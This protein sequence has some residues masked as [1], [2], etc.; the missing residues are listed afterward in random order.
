MGRKKN[1][2]RNSSSSKVVG[3]DQGAPSTQKVSNPAQKLPSYKVVDGLQAAYRPDAF[4]DVLNTINGSNNNNKDPLRQHHAFSKNLSRDQLELAP[5]KEQAVNPTKLSYSAKPSRDQPAPNKPSSCKMVGDR[6]AAGITG[7]TLANLCADTQNTTTNKAPNR[8][9]FPYVS[10]AKLGRDHAFPSVTGTKLGHDQG[11]LNNKERIF[12]IVEVPSAEMVEALHAALK[13]PNCIYWP[14]KGSSIVILNSKMVQF[15][16]MEE[17]PRNEVYEVRRIF[18]LIA[19]KG[20]VKWIGGQKGWELDSDVHSWIMYCD[21]INKLQEVYNSFAPDSIKFVDAGGASKSKLMFWTKQVSI[22][23]AINE[24]RNVLEAI[25]AYDERPNHFTSIMPSEAGVG[26]NGPSRRWARIISR[27]RSLMRTSN[28]PDSPIHWAA[29]GPTNRYK[30]TLVTD[31]MIFEVIQGLICIFQDLFFDE[32]T[33]AGDTDT[34]LGTTWYNKGVFSAAWNTEKNKLT[35][36]ATKK[37]FSLLLDGLAKLPG[38][39]A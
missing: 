25:L 38:P 15:H 9:T 26:R 8:H 12:D 33:V 32:G 39:S 10:G 34:G 18:Q 28:G 17:A 11:V 35:G 23:R 13:A 21:A 2:N 16:Q 22:W 6:R 14:E 7:R 24:V 30:Y 3:F 27:V 1:Q 5:K 36:F 37:Q 4:R 19:S 31:K 29:H 20:F